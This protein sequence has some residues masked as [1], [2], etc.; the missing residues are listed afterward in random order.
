LRDLEK[1]RNQEKQMSD[2]LRAAFGVL[3]VMVT[4]ILGTG[5]S[6]GQVPEPGIALL[7]AELPANLKLMQNALH[8]REAAHLPPGPLK[9]SN[10]AVV[11]ILSDLIDRSR[12]LQDL[13]SAGVTANEA[14]LV[15]AEWKQIK[16]RMKD[17]GL[18]SQDQ[19]GPNPPS[20]SVTETPQPSATP[21]PIPGSEAQPA[22]AATPPAPD[23]AAPSAQATNPSGFASPVSDL[24]KM[25][26]TYDIGVSPIFNT[27]GARYQGGCT[28][29][30]GAITSD[31]G[32]WDVVITLLAKQMQGFSPIGP[33]AQTNGQGAV[34]V[35]LITMD[36]NTQLLVSGRKAYIGRA[37]QNIIAPKFHFRNLSLN[38]V[39]DLL[40]SLK[41]NDVKI[42]AAFGTAAPKITLFQILLPPGANAAASFNAIEGQLLSTPDLITHENL[43]KQLSARA[44]SDLEITPRHGSPITVHIEQPISITYSAPQLT[45]DTIDDLTKFVGKLANLGTHGD[46][47]LAKASDRLTKADGTPGGEQTGQPLIIE[48]ECFQL[49]FAPGIQNGG[50][51]P[52]A[53]FKARISYIPETVPF[54]LKFSAEG[55]AAS[56]VT[57]P[58]R[59]AGSGDFTYLSKPFL[60]GWYATFGATGDSSY[61]QLAG[62]GVTEW[63]GGGKVELQTPVQTFFPVRSGND[64]K[65]TFTVE[66]GGIG[67]STP[68]TPTTFIVRGDFVYTLQP[69]AKIFLDF[70]AS[71][72]HANDARFAGRNDFSFGSFSG[73]YTIYNDW[74]FIA[75]YQCG[76][77]DPLYLKSCGWKMGFGVKPK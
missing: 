9:D 32:V 34:I 71:A 70:H 63:R 58:R 35:P 10:T 61:A 66:A 41:A 52:A 55:E 16:S 31:A 33:F 6:V 26:F 62:I 68:N 12:A 29:G 73:R 67:G 77:Q 60:G 14:P 43:V 39:T 20:S 54:T 5:A 19:P 17:A 64:Q 23:S 1:T 44:G 56:D 42:K 2:R 28:I 69:E 59:V 22:A 48:N 25:T 50:I 74:D 13:I 3:L 11:Q 45:G 40:Q 24:T 36:E 75:N 15:V 76:R 46:L 53:N 18:T 7:Q 4:Y 49:T 37:E 38:E 30:S 65:P 8:K 27:N 57:K 21:T 47:N 72:A 51:S